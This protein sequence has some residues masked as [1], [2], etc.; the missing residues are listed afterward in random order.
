[1]DDFAEQKEAWRPQRWWYAGGWRR[2]LVISDVTRLSLTLRAIKPPQTC[3]YDLT[4]LK[5]LQ[6]VEVRS[7]QSHVPQS[8]TIG[9]LSLRHQ[10]VIVSSW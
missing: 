7:M 4:E 6:S 10:R 2:S 8:V 3:T 9:M 5:E 1:M